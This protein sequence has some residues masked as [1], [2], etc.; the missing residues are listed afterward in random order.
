MD[1]RVGLWR[2]LSAEELML[3]N[4]GVG[5]DSWESLGLQGDPTNQCWIFIGKTDAEAEVPILWSPDAKSQFI[6]KDPDAGKDWGQE[7]KG[8]TED[9]MVG[10]HH[11]LNGHGFCGLRELVMDREASCGSWSHRVIHDWATELKLNW[12]TVIIL[13]HKKSKL[14][15]TFGLSYEKN[16][17]YNFKSSF[18]KK[19]K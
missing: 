14:L 3:L 7:G 6:R 8:T 13:L 19:Q 16:K 18:K 17:R 10:W 12:T 15:I 9:E 4:C 11:Q 5:E 1:V 2:K